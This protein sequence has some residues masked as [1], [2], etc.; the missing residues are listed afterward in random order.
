MS[1]AP[2]Q[3]YFLDTSVMRSLLLSTQAYQQYLESQLTDKKLYISNYVQ[4]EIIRSYLVNIISFYFVL[5]LD[6]Q[7]HQ[8]VL[9]LMMK[10]SLVVAKMAK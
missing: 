1:E 5:N 10:L 2:I 6:E 3:G 4:M 9:A 7:Y 8:L